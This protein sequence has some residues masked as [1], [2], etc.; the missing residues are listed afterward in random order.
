MTCQSML[1]LNHLQITCQS[2]SLPDVHHIRSLAVVQTSREHTIKGQRVTFAV[3]AAHRKP[4]LQPMFDVHSMAQRILKTAKQIWYEG[5]LRNWSKS[6]F[7]PPNPP[8]LAT[9]YMTR[10]TCCMP[11]ATHYM[12]RAT[13]CMIRIPQRMSIFRTMIQVFLHCM[14][15]LNKMVLIFIISMK[16]RTF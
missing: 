14:T 11:T 15:E 3:H 7:L 4:S 2:P 5:G 12:P 6:F 10:A 1:H 9:H 8:P 16:F 13:L